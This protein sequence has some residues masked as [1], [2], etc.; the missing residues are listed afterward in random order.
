MD[1]FETVKKTIVDTISCKEEEEG[2]WEAYRAKE[3]V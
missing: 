2:K 3:D 1:V